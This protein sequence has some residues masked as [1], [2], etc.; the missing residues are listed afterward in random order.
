MYGLG[1]G[2]YVLEIP[3]D[4]VS[5]NPFQNEVLWAYTIPLIPLA[6]YA[7]YS[8]YKYIVIDYDLTLSGCDHNVLIECTCQHS[9]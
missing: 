5:F 7:C 8:I 2:H 6:Q 3:L 4:T 9:T 1:N